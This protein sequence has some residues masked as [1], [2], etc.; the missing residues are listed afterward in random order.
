MSWKKSIEHQ[1]IEATNHKCISKELKQL[2]K[3]LL[4][5]DT[6]FNLI[7]LSSRG[8][9]VNLKFKGQMSPKTKNILLTKYG[10]KIYKY[11]KR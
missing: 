2:S 10:A 5:G 6:E 4:E 9:Y 11:F 8:V 7:F 1:I 3:D